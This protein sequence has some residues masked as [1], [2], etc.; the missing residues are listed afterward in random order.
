M[1][2]YGDRDCYTRLWMDE[3]NQINLIYGKVKY[4]GTE[5]YNDFSQDDESDNKITVVINGRK[6]VFDQEPVILQLSLVLA[7]EELKA[8]SGIVSKQL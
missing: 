8:S 7:F 1:T 2:L 4:G 5:V 3:L 6:M